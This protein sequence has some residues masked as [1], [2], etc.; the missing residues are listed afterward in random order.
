MCPQ[1]KHDCKCKYKYICKY[2][3]KYNYKY[4]YKYTSRVAVKGHDV[5]WSK[6]KDPV[7][8]MTALENKQYKMFNVQV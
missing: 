5:N 7:A 3:Y 2:K 1:Y 6:A 4:K 8:P